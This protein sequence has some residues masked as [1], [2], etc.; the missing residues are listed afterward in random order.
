MKRKL[1]IFF[2]ENKKLLAERGEP[3][4]KY[5][6][7]SELQNSS[8]SSELHKFKDSLL[9]DKRIIRLIRNLYDKKLGTPSLEASAASHRV[10]G[11]FYWVLRFLADIG[12]SRDDMPID[13][14]IKFIFLNQMPDGQFTIGY[15]RRNR[16][17]VTAVCMTAHLLYSIGK[18]GYVNT[19]AFNAGL[20]Y[21]LTTRRNDGGWHCDW[22]KQPGEKDE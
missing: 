18:L 20:N 9:N 10:Y 3:Y 15:R 7:T 13:D 17:T 22:R 1:K 16:I 19:R 14:A 2:N 6:F 8:K 21:I 11:S 5:I 4:S 12:L